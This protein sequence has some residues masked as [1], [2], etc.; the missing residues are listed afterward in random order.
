M[1]RPEPTS[2]DC[3]GGH[4]HVTEVFARQE[5]GL[6][7]SGDLAAWSGAAPGTPEA[8]TWRKFV[9]LTNS[10]FPCPSCSPARYERWR[11]GCFAPNHSRKSCKLCDP[12]DHR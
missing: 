7:T 3:T 2:C 10:V 8:E 6:P 12:K 9:A 4:R 11:A 1:P 5:A